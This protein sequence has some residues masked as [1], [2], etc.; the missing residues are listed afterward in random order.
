MMAEK[1][2]WQHEGRK[3]INLKKSQSI[4]EYENKEIESNRIKSEQART[5]HW[6]SLKQTQTD[7]SVHAKQSLSYI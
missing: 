2:K 3:E 7:H 5:V 1:N 4:K 6:L